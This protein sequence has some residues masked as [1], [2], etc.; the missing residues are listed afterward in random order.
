MNA[1]ALLKKIIMAC[2]H[3]CIK[4]DKTAISTK[5]RTCSTN[6]KFSGQI[7]KYHANEAPKIVTDKR[8]SGGQ[9]YMDNFFA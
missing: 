3:S 8:S 1:V 6:V 4:V 9:K 5:V 7:N 2:V